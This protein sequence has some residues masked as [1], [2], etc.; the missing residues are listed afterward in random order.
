MIIKYFETMFNGKTINI[1]L[2]LSNLN[3]FDNKNLATGLPHCCLS[4]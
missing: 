1:D 2:M 4:D 3:I